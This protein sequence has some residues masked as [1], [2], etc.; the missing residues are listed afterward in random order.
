M[1][2]F[3]FNFNLQVNLDHLY[4]HI[5]HNDNRF[6]ADEIQILT[7]QLCHTQNQ[8]RIDEARLNSKFNFFYSKHTSS[9]ILF[10]IGNKTS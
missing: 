6:S 4:Y 5:L 8:V 1:F 3:I 7:Y 2:A 10:V 9:S